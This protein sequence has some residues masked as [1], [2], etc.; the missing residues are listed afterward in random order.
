MRDAPG[1]PHRALPATPPPPEPAGPER[2]H[3]DRRAP[4]PLPPPPTMSSLSKL[5]TP[6]NLQAAA[7][8]GGTAAVGAL[9]L[10]QVRVGKGGRGGGRWVL[11]GIARAP[12]AATAARG[13]G[14]RCRLLSAIDALHTPAWPP[15]GAG[16]AAAPAALRAAARPAGSPACPPHTHALPPTLLSR[17][18]LSVT[19][20]TRRRPPRTSEG[21]RGSGGG[22]PNRG[23]ASRPPFW[24]GAASCHS[25]PPGQPLP[26]ARIAAR[27]RA[28]RGAA[29]TNQ[30]PPATR[31]PHTRHC[32]H[33]AAAWRVA[34]RQKGCSAHGPSP[35]AAVAA[36]PVRPAAW[37]RR[38]AGGRRDPGAAAAY[39]ATHY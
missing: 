4:P 36:R 31:H 8:W 2:T 20:S 19:W 33:G 29:Q 15:R 26:P 25:V 18:T 13:R 1:L 34:G 9:F 28:G 3:T 10:V 22:A 38:R 27:S 6:A 7:A 5:V 12:A 37:G 14:P 21:R 16:R 35:A 24:G 23:A 39:G 17:L 32:G 30:T 11:A